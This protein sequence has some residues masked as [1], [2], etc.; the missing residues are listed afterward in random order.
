VI[1]PPDKIRRFS[2]L[3]GTLFF[4]VAGALQAQ[5]TQVAGTFKTEDHLTPASANLR[6][7]ETVASQSVYGYV[8]FRLYDLAG[9]RYLALVDAGVT[10]LPQNVRG[11]I[12]GDGTLMDEAA[13]AF[14]RLVPT[15]G[16]SP[17][18]LV[19]EAVIYFA[20]STDGRRQEFTLR[21]YKAIPDQA[22]VDWASIAPAAITTP[23]VSYQLQTNASVSGYEEWGLSTGPANPA[24]N[25]ARVWVDS[26]TLKL[27]CKTTTGA[28]C[29][30]AGSG[31]SITVREV[32]LV[33]SVASTTILEFLQTSGFVVTDQTGGVAR[34]SLTL[35]DANIPDTITLTNLTQITTRNYSDLQ[36]IPS[37]FAPAAHAL[38]GA[39][40]TAAGLAIGAVLRAT[41]ATAF[42][43]GAVD[44]ADSD[45]VTGVLPDANVA[46]SITLTNLT[47]ITNRVIGDTTGDLAA[48]RVDDGGAAATQA[49]FSG[50][51]GAAGFRAI[52]AGD[53]PSGFIDATTDF[54]ATLCGTG[55]ILED[56]GASWACIATPAGGGAHNMLSTTHTDSTAAAVA[57][58]G[59]ITGIGVTPKWEL[60]AHPAAADRYVK[61]DANE[62]IWS[63]GSASGTG[64]CTNQFVR[65]LNSDAA[66]TCAT[67]AD[68]DVVDT[69]TA[70]NYLPLTGGTLTGALT[71]SDGVGDSPKVSFAA[72]TGAA[73]DIFMADA[74]DDL[75]IELSSI[76]TQQVEFENIGTGVM[77]VLIE[78]ADGMLT[79]LKDGAHIVSG[80]VADARLSANVSLLNQSIGT[81]EI[82]NNAVDDTKLRDAAATSVVG[83]AAG[84]SGDPAD[85]AASAD[86]QV[87]RRGAGTL[88]FGAVD[89][90]D[91]DAVTG[92]LPKAN[93]PAAVAY[94]DEANI[95][96][97]VQTVDNDLGVR[98]AEADVNGAEYLEWKGPASLAANVTIRW[99][100]IAE[101]TGTNGGALRVDATLTVV[102][103]DDDGGAGGGDSVEVEDADNAGTFTAID[104][105]ARFDDSGD[106]NFTFADGGAGGP[107][108]V[109]ATVRADAVALTTDTTGNY[110]LTVA[111]GTGIAVT[112]ADGEGATKTVALSFAGTLSGNP[113]LNAEECVPTTDGAGSGGFLCEGTTADTNEQLYLFPAANGADTTEFIWTAGN[114]LLVTSPVG[115]DVICF[116][117]VDVRW[118]N[119]T[120]SGYDT[121]QDEASALTKRAILNFI[122]AGVTCVD[123]AGSTRTDCTIPGGVSS[124]S[125]LT[126]PTAA[127]TFTSDATAETL[128]FNFQAAFTTGV[129]FLVRQQTGNPT[130]GTLFG[131]T[132]NDA[133]VLAFAINDGTSDKATITRAGAYTGVSFAAN[134]TGAG[135]LELLE[136]AAPSLV[137]NS[138][139]LVAPADITTNYQFVL[140][141]AS[142]T[143]FLLGT[144]ATNVNTVSFVGF[145]GTGNVVRDTAPT[146]L[147]ATI[148]T[149]D[150]TVDGV[151]VDFEAGA[152]EGYPR[153]AQSITPPATACDAA[154]EAGRL[155]FDTDADTDGSVFVCLGVA[156]WKDIDDDG[157]AGGAPTTAQYVV[158]ALDATLSAERVLTAGSGLTLTDGGANGNATL[159]FDFSDAGADPALAAG[160]CRFSN[161]GAN[162]A[163]WVCEGE[164]ANLIETRFRV[165][166]PT[167][168]DK[169]ITFPDAT[170]EVTLLGQTIEDA[171]LASNYSG[172]GGCTNQFARTLNDNAAPTCA[173]VAKADAVASFVHDDDANTFSANQTLS[174]G[175]G[176][177]PALVFTPQTGTSFNL[178]AAD[179]DDDLRVEA[180]TTATENLELIN[181]G[182]G[183]LDV[184]IET[185]DGVLTSLKDAAHLTTG[186]LGAARGGTGDDTSGTTGVPRIAAGNWTYDAGVSHLAA[187]TSADLAGVLTNETGSGGAAVF[188]TN[189]TLTD[190][191]VD[192]VIEFTESAGD[193]TCA[194][195]NFNIKAN[196]T[197][198]RLRGCENGTL[199]N[200]NQAAGSVA[201]SSLTNPSAN[202]SLTMAANTSTFTTTTAVADLFKWANT[203][204]ATAGTSQ[205]SPFLSLGGT[206]WNG[207]ASAEDEWTVQV[208]VANGTNGASTLA[209][210][211]TGS[212]G[213]AVLQAPGF[214]AT[215]SGAGYLEM[216]EGTAPSLVANSL[217]LLAPADVAAAGTAYIFPGTSTTGFLKNTNSSGTGTLSI[218]ATIG[219]ADLTSN[220]SGVGGCTNQFVRTLNDNAAPTCASVSLTADVS[221]IL[222]GANGGTNN[223]FMDFTG[224]A[225]TLKTFTLPN[226]SATILTTNATLTVA[227]GGTGATSLTG[228][229]QGNGTAAFT[230]IANSSTV[231]QTL[232]VTGASA[233]GWGALDLADADAVTG[234]LPDANIAA[235]ITRDSEWPPATAT[236]TNKTL[237]VE[238]TGNVFTTVQYVILMAAACQN[239]TATLL[240]DTPTT[241]PAVA[242]CI[243]G[244]NT[245]KGV[246]DFA[247]SANLS[248]QATF[249]LPRD[250]TGVVDAR[251][252][253]LTT[254]TTGNVVWQLATICVADAETD[255][256][257]FNTASTV[258]DAAQGTA[259]QT[260]DADIT[261]VTMTGCAAGEL[262]HVKVQRDSAHASDTL[263]ATA[264]LISLELTLRRA[265]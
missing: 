24:A 201:W 204:A 42:A 111:A 58:G 75:R 103:S 79:S 174:D 165:T 210:T 176:D 9:K 82:E 19:Y 129:Q 7:L 36:N 140:P 68:A 73:F 118:E 11:F 264:R 105:T 141:A 88:A 191:T 61:T 104:T 29:N 138:V 50:A 102:C 172:V 255:D 84:T 127:T 122:G 139:Q 40:H 265:Q 45:A 125:D 144:N 231:G 143:G 78:T 86:G 44:L 257:A 128:T 4:C 27:S 236:L 92:V 59:L 219:D 100:A 225:T 216:L 126:A 243:T 106:I 67:V 173:T 247:D 251:F 240:W 2:L 54:A 223:G 242:A 56:Q 114:V 41:S 69:I 185:S 133:D 12:K 117:G 205:S 99:G 203:T 119:C 233:Y 116:D 55:Q 221:G 261:G 194:A 18:G 46:D 31:G 91:T 224:P 134:A 107:D 235:T 248:M 156:G 96:T 260:N 38:V 37:T 222:P 80:T 182:T 85:I 33:P 155:Y 227:Q 208:S 187:S 20:E 160:E 112:G 34:V 192:D 230:A 177:S 83:R 66:P 146:I 244:T 52:A 47:Q 232:R 131:I 6:V 49:L 142:A 81:A 214:S 13:N 181:V 178:F 74:D 62:V 190:V 262:L 228:L 168:A 23:A 101:C 180:N 5:N 21:E 137:A 32:D 115:G 196:S 158:M 3:L 183:V 57:R 39:D 15:A 218:Q 241:S 213:A 171:E 209:F 193:A 217:Q 64:S 14:V 113:A 163:G 199:F 238:A 87:L 162:P 249:P 93:L 175:V 154:A 8:D 72:Q 202:L 161:E 51:A 167:T 195:G 237:D 211:H 252:K 95:F 256:P 121:I 70:S 166:D 90:A 10:H 226:A 22:S 253:W 35:T 30:P 28:D 109:T 108:T 188:G 212:T 159:A 147:G 207:T 148:A 153:L 152:A 48:S 60:R 65:A 77:D 258:T 26:S 220:Y 97:M 198:N 124:W 150:L 132:V 123:N 164:T 189:P 53:L 206:Y 17:A 1:I 215:A 25:L 186:Q 246:A 157:A 169:V 43:F 234:L 197:A 135:Y 239:A 170:G 259:N 98:L 71:L 120:P 184:L 89:L 63:S 110:V 76:F 263:A 130:G 250:W 136:G 151:E 179:A 229:L 145:T 16:S 94:E 254:A 149:T 200:I 245:Q